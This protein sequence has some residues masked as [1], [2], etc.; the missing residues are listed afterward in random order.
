MATISIIFNDLDIP[1]SDIDYTIEPYEP[2]THCGN[3]STPASGGGVIINAVWMTLRGIDGKDVV[4]NISPLVDLNYLEEA[5]LEA[6]GI[7]A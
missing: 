5:V 3:D 2:E 6:E 1:K 4:V 7:L